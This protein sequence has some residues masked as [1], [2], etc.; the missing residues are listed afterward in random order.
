MN[1][2]W[3][4][5]ACLIAD[6]TLTERLPALIG[7]V[8]ARQAPAVELVRPGTASHH[9]MVLFDG[10]GQFQPEALV[11]LRAFLSDPRS[12]IDHPIHPRLATL[13]VAISAHFGGR[14]L[15]VVSGYRHHNRHHK[16]SRHTRGRAI[17]F[18]VPGMSNRALFESLRASFANVGVG[19]YPNSAFVHL[20]VRD[21]SAVWVDF[22][23]SGQVPCYSRTP[24]QDLDSG[25]ADTLSYED[26]IARGCIRP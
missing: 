3:F 10:Q 9:T 19:Y 20:D 1:A 23:G 7:P 25:V 22:S 4:W 5:I 21:R 6:T 8:D 14:P 2:L 16:R 11:D 26:A 24:Q 18:R 12:E 15:E 13:L 17:D